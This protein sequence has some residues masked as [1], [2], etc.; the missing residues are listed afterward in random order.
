M[1]LS[2]LK[3]IIIEM[4]EKIK[5]FGRSLDLDS[6]EEAIAQNENLMSEDGF[7]N[8]NITA[9]KVINENNKLKAKFEN[10]NNLSN[11]IEEL[12]ISLELLQEDNDVELQSEVESNVQKI[13]T[14]LK[15]YETQ[16]L[17]DGPYDTNN[18]ILEIH[19]G[20]GGTESQDWG[21]MLYRMYQRWA[22]HHGF[23]IEVEDYQDGDEA[24][25]KSVT[26]M[27]KGINAYG[28]LRSEHGVHRL[29]RIS[30]FDSAGRRHTS[31]ASVE[32]M[33]ELDSS[34]EIEINPDDLRIDVFRSS[35]AGGQHINKTSSAVRI[36]HLPTGFVVS[37][38]AQRSQLQNRETAMNMLKAKL[39]QKELEEKAKKN[40]EI[41]G[42]QMEI[43]WGSQI[44]SYVF[45]PYTMVKDHRTN[46]ETGNGQ[47][48]LDGNLDE[49]I[50]SYLQ[51]QLQMKNPE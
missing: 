44:R 40:A 36:T 32:I 5:Q 26:L 28:L 49:F 12:Q 37:S 14:D 23:E 2:E 48:V 25:I 38:Q 19:P 45:H 34:I 27:I 33:P 50:N 10:F 51:W 6:L 21:S 4:E 46:Y 30:P 15:N 17:L 24:G 31:F 43:G 13:Q 35:G 29:V 9:Q 39:Y 16:M 11:S 22:E 20:A 18:A 47:A 3:N 42:E 41:K 7:W 1:E 8:D